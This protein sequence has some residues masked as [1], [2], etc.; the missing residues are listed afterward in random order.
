VP[1]LHFVFRCIVDAAY[2]TAILVSEAFLD[3]ILKS[4]G[5]IA[6]GSGITTSRG[7]LAYVLAPQRSHREP[8]SADRSLKAGYGAIVG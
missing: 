6:D 7:V 2:G 4:K 5:R 1:T 8:A 3:S